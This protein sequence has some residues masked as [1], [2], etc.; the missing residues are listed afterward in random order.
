M[1]SDLSLVTK[2]K[3]RTRISNPG[4]VEEGW[5]GDL[6]VEVMKEASVV[7]HFEENVVKPVL[8]VVGVQSL[9]GRATLDVKGV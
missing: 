5:S 4:R 3:G 2:I 1:A 8:F 6:G 9:V 7:S